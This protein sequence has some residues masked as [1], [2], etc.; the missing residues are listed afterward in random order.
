MT[1]TV[2]SIPIFNYHHVCKHRGLVTVLPET[3]DDQMLYLADNGYHSV[4][5]DELADFIS[6]GAPLPEKSVMLTFDD[7]YLDNYV[8][9]YPILKKYGLR[10][11]LFCITDWIGDGARRNRQ[12]AASQCQD[13][14]D[15]ALTIRA[16]KKDD[17][18]LRW[19]E[20]EDM[21]KDNVFYV[22]SHTHTHARWDKA[23]LPPI[24]QVSA[25]DQDLLKSKEV[26]NSRLGID[27]KH[28]CWPQGFFNEDYVHAATEA[29]FEYLYTAD[30]HIVE[31]GGNPLKIG[32]IGTNDQAGTWFAA[33]LWI[34]SRP[35]V[36]KWYNRLRGY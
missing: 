31:T 12:E 9:A 20:I 6:N 19:S 18:M 16:G 11:T 35:T 27:S 36:A 34:Y 17:V 23:G 8:Y 32:R 7:G 24:A 14:V 33:Q 25:L 15:C 1:D 21:M 13:H 10:A 30:R 26:L 4:T 28:L 2:Q 29:G 22:H 3:F 5:P